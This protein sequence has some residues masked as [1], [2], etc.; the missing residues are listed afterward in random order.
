V[1]N[2]WNKYKKVCCPN[3]DVKLSLLSFVVYPWDTMVPTKSAAK[4]THKQHR[5]NVPQ[6]ITRTIK[7]YVNWKDINNSIL[8]CKLATHKELQ[9]CNLCWIGVQISVQP[10]KYRSMKIDGTTFFPVPTLINYG[11]IVTSKAFEPGLRSLRRGAEIRRPTYTC[12]NPPFPSFLS[13]L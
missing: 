1:H 8:T 2:K 4:G 9:S 7:Y 10:N 11:D 5:L 6:E 13:S 12:P 3:H